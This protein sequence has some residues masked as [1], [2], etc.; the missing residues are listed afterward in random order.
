[1]AGVGQQSL[2]LADVHSSVDISQI[3]FW[4]RMFAFAGPAYLVSVG[5]MD[6]GNWATDLEG[7]AR[8]GYR[9][10]WVLVMSNAMAIL[11]QTLSARLGIVNGRDLAQ[12]CREAYPR[13]L[14]FALWILSEIAI[15]ACDLA[16]VL[17]A[18]IAL[19]LLFHIPLLIGV[20]LTA[21]DTLLLLW[22]QSFGIRAIEAFILSLIT[23]MAAC[24]CIELFWARP[25]AGELFAGLAP[26]LNRS[27][28]YLA[29]TILGATVM[30]HNM[31]LHSALVQTRNIGRTESAKRMACRFNLIDSAVALNGAMFVNCAILVLAAAVFFKR[32]IIVT[33]I[34]QA[35]VLLVPLL[36]ASMAGVLFAVALL[37]SGQSSTLT[38][39]MAGQVVMEGFLNIRMRPWL[40]RLITRTLAV[41]PAALTIYFAGDQATLGLLLLS[42]AILSMQLPF[43]I[44]PLIHFT[45]DRAR[46]GSFANAGW[47]RW[48]SWTT[49]AVVIGLNTWLAYDSIEG[50]LA[51]A[52]AWRGLVGTVAISISAG[53]AILLLWV[54]FEPVISGRKR[55]RAA[56]V[57]P[58]TEGAAAATPVYHRILV[59]LDHTALD[60]LAIS[61]AAAMAKLYGAKLYLLHVEEGVTSQIYGGE[62]STAEVEAGQAYLDRIARSLQGQGIAVETAILYSTSPGKEIVRYAREIQPDLL[63][64]GA[65]GHG[66]LKDLIFGTTISPVR[67]NLDIPVLIVRPGK[68]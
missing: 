6:P 60:L 68:G 61:H 36:G 7:G 49:A 55:G 42:Q 40:R 53:L 63:I 3:S 22:F 4:R 43:A 32:G 38:G 27:S 62:S 8:F 64:M 33:E 15:A 44:V 67:H 56:V 54:T 24:F 39:T 17:G 46:M 58:E 37:C 14:S 21:S 66:G 23:V 47:V 28:L 20:I 12:A 52:G 11:L 5:Y 65:H 19:N 16:E 9:L 57:F 30:P 35:H 51:G 10:L 41:I 2:S 26:R 45:S 25:A 31:Y 34:Q 59:P 50:W 18:A 29:V 1:M 13:S 48:L